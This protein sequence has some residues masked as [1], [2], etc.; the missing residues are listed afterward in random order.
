[1]RHWV[2]RCRPYGVISLMLFAGSATAQQARPP[3][4]GQAGR[5]LQWF[6]IPADA[7]YVTG[8][9]WTSAGS[10]FR[11]YGVQACLRG[12]QFTNGQGARIDCGEAS[13]TMLASLVRDL[14]PQCYVV[15]S[16]PEA[17]SHIVS[18]VAVLTKGA[19]SGSRLDLGT[20]LIA[21]GWAFAAL[22]VD[23][24][25][26]HE[27]YLVAQVAAQK[28]RRGLWQFN[29]VPDPNIAILRAMRQGSNAPSGQAPRQ[30]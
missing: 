26:V 21:T 20:T 30:K 27:P 16:R 11:L 4:Q 8:D 28:S 3:D 19:S 24:K 13:L 9:T 15:S 12:T 2:R 7:T 25:P 10:T 5:T 1:M 29:D 6:P 17:R 23:A 14:S 18:C 22:T